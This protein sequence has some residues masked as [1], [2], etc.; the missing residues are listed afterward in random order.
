MSYEF[1]T[2]GA[3]SAGTYTIIVKQQDG[4]DAALFG[5]GQY[6]TTAIVVLMDKTNLALNSKA[7]ISVVGPQASKLSIT[8]LDSNDNIV[9]NDSIVT[10]SFGKAKHT[11]DLSELS[12]G[13]YRAAVSTSN[14]QD[15][16]K[17]SIGLEPG[18][19]EISL[20]STSENYSPGES[21]LV[22]GNRGNNARLTI[23]LFEPSGKVSSQ[24]ETFSDAAGNFSTEE[25]GVPS[26]AELGVWKITCLLYTSD[27]AD[28]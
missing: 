4:S 19:G 3:L 24:T 1:D 6:P 7:I 22:I 26:D 13:I 14:I 10:S 9:I 11:I 28:E 15:S 17:F 2:Y 21:I 5:L 20:I 25:I 12:S 18:S 27:A 23:T 16:V 8:V